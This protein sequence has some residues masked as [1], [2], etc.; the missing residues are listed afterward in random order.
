MA[1]CGYVTTLKNV[2][3]HPNADRLVLADCFGNTVCVTN[4]YKEGDIGVY[5]PVDG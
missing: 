1:Y 5:F 4:S 3:K 2:R